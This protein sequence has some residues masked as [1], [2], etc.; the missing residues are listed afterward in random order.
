MSLQALMDSE[1]G[2]NHASPESTKKNVRS[3]LELLTSLTP[4]CEP[5]SAPATSREPSKR[6]RPLG[7]GPLPQFSGDG[8]A[9][10]GI[11]CRRR[12]GE[13]M[14]YAAFE[15]LMY[16]FASVASAEQIVA[17]YP[18]QINE[19]GAAIRYVSHIFAEVLGRF[20]SHQVV[21]EFSHLVRSRART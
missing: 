10:K 5:T 1:E 15:H 16:A 11:W 7:V 12:G 9:K 2:R 6:N 13:A 17:K 4:G 14:P 20:P 19:A 18:G 3:Y 21:H 8:E